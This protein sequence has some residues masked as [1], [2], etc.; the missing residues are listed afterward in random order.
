MEPER[1]RQIER[2]YHAALECDPRRRSDYLQRACGTDEALRQEIESLLAYETQ[3]EDFIEAPALEIAARQNGS[4]PFGRV[5]D[6][7]KLVLEK[8]DVRCSDFRLATGAKLGPYEILGPLG[9]GGMGEIYSARDCRLG[10][11]V[12]LKILGGRWMDDARSRVRFEREARVISS[13]NHPSICTL[14]DIGRENEVDYLVMECVEGET[15]ADGIKNGPLP[16]PEVLR[17]AI[18]IARALYY[19]HTHGTRP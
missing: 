7:L 9:A 2:L 8:S 3:S 10:R 12:A 14:Y 17:I 1:W 5:R 15:L 18:E 13:L 6:V 19:A 16:L 11:I 4:D